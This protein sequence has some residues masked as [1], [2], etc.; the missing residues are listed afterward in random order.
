MKEN[1]IEILQSESFNVTDEAGVKYVVV[2][3]SDFASVA[4]RIIKLFEL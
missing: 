2:E 1:I 3:D 4:E